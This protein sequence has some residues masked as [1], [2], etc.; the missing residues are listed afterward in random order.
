MLLSYILVL[1]TQ[2]TWKS[3]IL[4]ALEGYDNIR[5]FMNINYLLIVSDHTEFPARY[6]LF[7]LLARLDCNISCLYR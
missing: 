2:C 3:Y 5:G 4:F 1:W 7:Q 6:L